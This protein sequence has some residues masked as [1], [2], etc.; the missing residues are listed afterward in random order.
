MNSARKFRYEEKTR[1]VVLLTAIT[2]IVEIYFGLRT[3]SMALLA[4][5][6]HMGSHVLALGM[7]WIAYILVRKLKSIKNLPGTRTRSYHC[8]DTAAVL[9]C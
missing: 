7:S 8:R 3:R 4:D 1:L 5:G 9:F 6:I 2:M